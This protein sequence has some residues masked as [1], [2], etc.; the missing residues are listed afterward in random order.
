MIRA[1]LALLLFANGVVAQDLWDVVAP[2]E[3]T[4]TQVVFLKAAKA[5]LAEVNGKVAI[6][7]EELSEAREYGV[8]V[9]LPAEVKWIEIHPAAKPFPPT[10]Q[11]PFKDGRFLIRGIPGERFYVSS[12]GSDRPLW[13][14]TIVAAGE[15][16]LPPP[17]DPLPVDPQPEPA[18][19]SGPI[20]QQLR[21]LSRQKSQALG[22]AATAVVLKGTIQQV[23]D[24]VRAM[25]RSGQCPTLDGAKN[26]MV[27][28]IDVAMLG[29]TSPNRDWWLNWRRPVSDAIKKASP[30]DVE[31][32]LSMM[33]A[34][35]EGL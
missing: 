16:Q 17:S 7:A 24:S 4:Q 29:R 35:A 30:A 5:E 12:R 13:F 9:T 34:A 14:E 1:F 21:E 8:I 6:I 26:M 20:L 22:D 15:S 3:V 11:M 18:P 19:P 25:C 10:V 27:Q 31:T 28:A 32:Y 33:L 2:T 23:A